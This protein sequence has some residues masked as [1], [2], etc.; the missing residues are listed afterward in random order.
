MRPS[1]RRFP[2]SAAMAGL[3][4]LGVFLGTAAAS[5]GGTVMPG[6]V[7]G[8][9]DVSGLTESQLLAAL[10][11]AARAIEERSLVLTAEERSFVRRPAGMGIRIDVDQSAARAMAAG[12]DNP[13][14]WLAH[15][16]FG[17]NKRLLWTPR[18]DRRALREAL[19]GLS[20]E[21][22]REAKSGEIEIDGARLAVTPPEAGITLVRER[23]ESVLIRGAIVPSGEGG[24]ALPVSETQPQIGEELIARVRSE[25]EAIVSAPVEFTLNGRSF[26]LTRESIGAT[27]RTRVVLGDH[28]VK[29]TS[30][31]LVLYVD[32]ASLLQQMGAAAPWAFRTPKD[33]SFVVEKTRVV[34][35]PAEEGLSVDGDAAAA[36]VASLKE[37]PARGVIALTSRT[38]P[39]AFTT[40]AAKALGI[41]ERVSTF[42]TV[43]DPDLAP[44]VKNIDLIARAIDGKIVKPGE[45]FSL[46][47]ATGE[48]TPEKGY[49]VAQVIVDGELVPG[50]GG[51]VCQ[52]GTATFNAALLAGLPIAERHNHSLYISRYPVGRDAT[53]YYGQYDLRFRNDTPH[54]LL[55]KANVNYKFLN[56]S[57]Y[58]TSLLRTVEFQTSPQRNFRTPTTKYIDDP[59]LFRGQEVV[60]EAGKQGFDVTVTRTV[61]EGGKVIRTDTFVSRYRPWKR[62]VRRGTGPPAPTPAPAPTD[63]SSPSPTAMPS[64]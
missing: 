33:A 54:G 3:V 62:I 57:I 16:F 24:L 29:G 15:R 64:P 7:I 56:V 2:L 58:S 52:A 37:T 12:R 20:R 48:R 9:I 53:L 43:F 27:L 6:V 18:V 8:G 44:R 5:Q 17:G 30:A 26:G 46:N 39:P 11:P 63:T 13:L 36:A 34:L 14:E 42:T 19:L 55:L 41:I 38:V 31:Q 61:R 50:L 23:A 49:Q 1:R 59:K 25:A 4:L 22:D 47:A 51:G 32:A 60:V 28:Q 40:E 21:V 45:D 35:V 10:R